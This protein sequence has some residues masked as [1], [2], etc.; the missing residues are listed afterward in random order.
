[1]YIFIYST[2]PKLK[3]WVCGQHGQFDIQVNV[4]C[5]VRAG[6]ILPKWTLQIERVAN[7]NPGS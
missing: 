3:A 6:G 5:A 2:I 7:E 4:S 1:M